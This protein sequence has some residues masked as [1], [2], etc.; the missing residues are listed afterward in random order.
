MAGWVLERISPSLGPHPKPKHETQSSTRNTFSMAAEGVRRQPEGEAWDPLRIVGR[1]ALR[2]AVPRRS[3][4]PYE[5]CPALSRCSR[6]LPV[7]LGDKHE[8]QPRFEAGGTLDPLQTS[9]MR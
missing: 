3:P 4:A 2:C 5:R 8:R 1:C 7:Q 9:D 6:T